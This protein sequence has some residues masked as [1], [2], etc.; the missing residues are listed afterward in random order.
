MVFPRPASGSRGGEDA[1]DELLNG[2]IFDA[3]RKA[4]AL[5]ERRRKE[6]NR[7][8]PRGSPG[9]RPPAPAAGEPPSIE[10]AVG[11]AEPNETGA[12]RAR[13]L[14]N[15]RGKAVSADIESREFL[16]DKVRMRIDFSMTD[17]SRGVPPPP[18]QKSVPG[19]ARIIDLPDPER[20]SPR[21]DL[22]AAIARRESRRSFRREML[23]PEELS[24]LLWATQGVRGAPVAGHALRNVPSAGCRH[25]FE[26]YLAAFSVT[27]LET[28]IYRYLPLTNQLVLVSRPE[29]LAERTARAAL[30]QGFA[31]ASAV[32]FIWT[33]IPYRMEWRYGRASYKVIALDA[34]HVCQNLYLACEA[35]GCG[36]CAI[37]AYDQELMDELVGADGNDEFVIYVA[38]VGKAIC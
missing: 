10:R 14:M 7:L 26:T 15:R 19:E 23:S 33:T 28:G 1:P 31:G 18:L 35:I 21:V 17:Q 12:R 30:G 11:V 20:S 9:Y 13:H 3:F 2:E 27:G 22:A 38:P 4:Q 29:R 24:F 34:G 36:T 6:Y 16:K 32:T 8:R 37:A 25:S 5:V